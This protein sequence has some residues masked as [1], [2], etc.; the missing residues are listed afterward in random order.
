MSIDLDFF[1]ALMT[2]V[3]ASQPPVFLGIFLVALGYGLKLIASVP[4]RL[5][6]RINY[7]VA[8][9]VFP[10]IARPDP[11]SLPQQ[12]PQVAE[13][14]RN[15]MGGVIIATVAWL[16]HAFILK[17]IIDRFMPQN[18]EG[19]TKFFPKPPDSGTKPP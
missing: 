10:L 1:T 19:E 17:R 12:F 3:F 9:I 14:I 13:V 18:G 6:P 8:M 16:A 4:N 11:A 5:I 2:K 15:G 7:L